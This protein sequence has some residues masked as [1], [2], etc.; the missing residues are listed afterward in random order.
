[1]N[2]QLLLILLLFGLSFS[3]FGQQK[4]T[5]TGRVR[6]PEGWTIPG[7]S[8]YVDNSAIGTVTDSVGQFTLK[9]PEDTKF[10]RVSYMGY[11]ALLVNIINK[12]NV[13]VTLT[14]SDN[15]LG[16]VIVNGY[17]SISKRKNTTAAAVIDYQK[18]RQTGVSGVDQM[19]EGQVAGVSVGSLN[20]GPSAAPKIRIRGTVSLNGNQDPLWVLDGIPLEG[21]TMPNLYDKDNID[22]LRNL[23]I[24][25][26]NP[27]D[28]ADITILKDAAATAIYGARASNG[29]IVI[30]TKK[31]KKGPVSISFNANTF[32]ASKP[33][34]GKLNL[35]NATEKVDFELGLASRADLTYRDNQG[36]VT[37]ILNQNNQLNNFRQNGF[38]G[39][40]SA[41]QDAINGLRQNNTNWNDELYQTAL[42]QQYSLSLSGGND[43]A[44]YYFSGGY[45][46][47]KGSTIGT[48][49]E[50]FNMTLK[51]DFNLSKKLRAGVAIFASKSDRENY[52]TEVD[53]FTSP[54]RYSRNVNPYQTVR[55]ANGN[56]VYD[57]DIFGTSNLSGDVYIPFNIIEER[58]NTR[59]TLGNKSIKS[60]IDADYQ[61][62]KNL[63]LHSEFG[64]Q[65]E[66][67]GVEKYAGVTSYFARK[68]KES[69]RYYNSTSKN[70]EYF[71]PEGGI[72]QNQQTSLFQYNWKTLLEY[73][74]VFNE[75]HEIEALAGSE[76]R[77][78]N[79]ENIFTKGFGFN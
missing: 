64:L 18:L 8:V 15:N 57:Q 35:M 46:N 48:G 28:I 29:V 5:I 52:L 38:S 3:S 70:Y 30:T 50:R 54:S 78:N 71:L 25:G 19:L 76:F 60:I 34:L 4:T 59:Y 67:T 53:A 31:G 14:S 77:R 45:Y 40:N 69:T 72:I 65:F 11:N 49:F 20:G 62:I 74:K 75:K 39:L 7:A 47:E 42:N 43:Q 22:E 61:I 63:K 12:K 32:V 41:T 55:D 66:D 23:P 37:R 56:F 44:T 33:D 36:G 6:G 58:Q 13:E 1:M 26:L 21:T 24:A 27:D 17:T 9:V 2:K 10:I 68:M 79:N 51:T 16:E 73:K